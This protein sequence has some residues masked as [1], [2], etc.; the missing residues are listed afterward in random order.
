MRKVLIESNGVNNRDTRVTD[1][2]S[3]LVIPNIQHIDITMDVRNIDT[4]KIQ[5][6]GIVTRIPV[7][8]DNVACVDFDII[9]PHCGKLYKSAVSEHEIKGDK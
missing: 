6:I 5:M 1:V 2:E 3:G 4:A 9:C 8:A 7:G